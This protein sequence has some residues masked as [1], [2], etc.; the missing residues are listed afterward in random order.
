MNEK[1]NR[2]MVQMSKELSDL[3]VDKKALEAEIASLSARL[4]VQKEKAEQ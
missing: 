1:H 3:K 2:K 4:V